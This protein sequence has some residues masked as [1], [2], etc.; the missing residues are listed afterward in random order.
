ML[1]IE[2]L[3]VSYG[4]RH[5]LENVSLEVNS[6]E[7]LALIGPN[8]AGKSTLV[9]AV[10]GVVPVR[11]GKVRTNGDDLLFLSPMQRARFL[12]VVPQVVSMPPAFTVWETVLMGRTPYLNFLGQISVKDEQIARLAL[13]KVDALDL[14]ERRVG[15]LSGGEQQRVLLAR[16]L[17]QSTPILLLDEP[18]TNLDLHYQVDFMEIIRTLAHTDG[19][20]V[21]IALHDLNLAARYAN[22]VALLVSGEIQATGTPRQVLTPGLI[23]AAYHLPVQVVPHPF[24]DVPLVLPGAAKPPRS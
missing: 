2:N 14:A 11:S 10:S 23:S 22:R 13:Q 8:G 16:A 21:L 19:L 3:S 15:E 1:R 5:V 24:A 7:V 18:T 9:R 4:S 20:A 6:G 12:A 17:A